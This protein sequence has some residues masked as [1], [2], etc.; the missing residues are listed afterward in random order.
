MS[1]SARQIHPLEHQGSRQTERM[2]PTLNPDNIE[3][4]GRNAEQLIEFSRK[5]SSLLKFPTL[6]GRELNWSAFFTTLG[7]GGIEAIESNKELSPHAALFLAFLRLYDISRHH[8]NELSRKHLDFFY[9][10]VLG[11]KPRNPES[12]CAHL[13]FELARNRNQVEVPEATNL[14]AGDLRY[15]T[16]RELFANKATITRL[17]SIYR[18]DAGQG[19]LH[20][21]LAANSSDGEGAEIEHEPPSWQAF[22]HPLLP[23]MKVGFAFAGPILMLAEGTRNIELTLSLDMDPDAVKSLSS[24]DISYME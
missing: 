1:E 16:T 15:E 13:L 17:H 14:K 23:R 21:A 9:R 12:D 7:D 2:D 8:L 4:D 22:G 6:D 11:L 5:F 20:Y 18:D 10:E 19:R 24:N 3:I